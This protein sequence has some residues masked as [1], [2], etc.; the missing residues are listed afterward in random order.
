MPYK[1]EEH[2]LICLQVRRGL[3]KGRRS[4]L[5]SGQVGLLEVV[6][7]VVLL[8]CGVVVRRLLMVPQWWASMRSTCLSCSAVVLAL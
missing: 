2:V 7:A 5:T 6:V 3:R 8:R 1:W 4:G